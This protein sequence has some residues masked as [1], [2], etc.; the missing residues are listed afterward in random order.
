MIIKVRY[1]NDSFYKDVYY[2]NE[3]NKRDIK[4]YEEF[5]MKVVKVEKYKNPLRFKVISATKARKLLK[6]LREENFSCTLEE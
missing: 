5:N 4:K 1:A 3:I 6:K 2:I